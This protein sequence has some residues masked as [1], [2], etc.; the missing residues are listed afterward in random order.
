LPAQEINLKRAP[1]ECEHKIYWPTRELNPASD[2]P[3]CS[4]CTVSGSPEP[5]R[6]AH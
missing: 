3:F 5:P 1:L 4:V 2:R 6:Q